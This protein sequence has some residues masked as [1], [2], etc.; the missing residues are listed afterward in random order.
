MNPVTQ[1][2]LG[3]GSRRKNHKGSPEIGKAKVGAGNPIDLLA[4]CKNTLKR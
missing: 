1:K 3:D 2:V 4:G